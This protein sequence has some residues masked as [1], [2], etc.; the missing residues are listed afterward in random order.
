[1]TGFA[2]FNFTAFKDMAGT[3]RAAGALEHQPEDEAPKVGFADWK[4]ARAK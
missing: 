1:M 2:D 4:P 3:L